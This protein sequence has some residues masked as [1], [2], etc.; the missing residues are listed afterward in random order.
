M[1]L[2]TVKAHNSLISTSYW[3]AELLCQ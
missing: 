2:Q 3:T 1:V